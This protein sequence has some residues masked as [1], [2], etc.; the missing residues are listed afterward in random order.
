[1]YQVAYA[2]MLKFVKIYLVQKSIKN[3]DKL[4]DFVKEE[5]K[6]FIFFFFKLARARVCAKRSSEVS[7]LIFRYFL[8]TMNGGD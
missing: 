4:P 5:Q 2:R 8:E 7:P 1:M 3:F 6:F